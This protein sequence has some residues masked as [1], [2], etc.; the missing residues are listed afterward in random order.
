M[1]E[2][3]DRAAVAVGGQT[4]D[5][6]SFEQKRHDLRFVEDPRHQLAILQVIDGQRRF[7]FMKPALDL[8]HPI[9]WVVDGFA[10]SQQL[11]GHRLQRKGGEIPERRF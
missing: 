8:I 4:V 2:G 3:G 10:F 1:A 5:R 7:V 11:A 9:P 6:R